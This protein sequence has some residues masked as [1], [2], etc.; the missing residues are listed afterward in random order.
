MT[1][2]T[3]I[4]LP[5]PLDPVETLDPATVRL[6]DVD[7]PSAYPCRRCLR[8]ALPGERVVLLS[9]DPFLGDSPYRQPGPIFV[10]AEPCS[11]VPS[12]ELPEQLMRRRLSVRSFDAAHL[13]LD[14]VVVEGAALEATADALLADD[15]VAYLHVHN[16]GPGCFA[17]RIDRSPEADRRSRSLTLADAEPPGSGSR[18][19]TSSRERRA[20][21]GSGVRP[22]GG[23]LTPADADPRGQAPAS[24]APDPPGRGAPRAPARP[25]R[26]RRARRRGHRARARPRRPDRRAR[27]GPGTPPARAEEPRR[28]R[29][30]NPEAQ[31]R[32]PRGRSAPAR[33]RRRASEA[34]SARY[35]A[36]RPAASAR[37]PSSASSSRTPK[38]AASAGPPASPSRQSPWNGQT[39]AKSS[40]ATRGTAMWPISGW[41]SPVTSRPPLTAPPPIPVP[42]VT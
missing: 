3:L 16:A 27:A 25:G 26:A 40:P 9:Y 17:V 8:D 39:P 11:P 35:A 42:T 10:H 18:R 7:E 24:P 5:T 36:A 34:P 19:H 30:R 2:L 31:R 32:R 6:I 1:S 4:P 23:S 38:R 22:Q 28:R 41:T 20:T 14:G 13:M 21:P 37:T 33:A 12:R 29:R 15:A